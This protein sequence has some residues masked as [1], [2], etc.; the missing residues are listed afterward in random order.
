[1]SQNNIIIAFLTAFLFFQYAI[2]VSADNDGLE[3]LAHIVQPEQRTSLVLDGGKPFSLKEG[4]TLDFDLNLRLEEHNFGYICRIIVNDT[5]NVDI[6]ANAGWGN[7]Q[8]SMIVKNHRCISV[9]DIRSLPGFD[10][11]KWT[12]VSVALN[13]I[14]SRISLKIGEYKA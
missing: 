4:F 2:P 10:F 13:P 7:E 11:G 9:K 3:F 1:M 8:I 12:H 6:L 5:L 14:S